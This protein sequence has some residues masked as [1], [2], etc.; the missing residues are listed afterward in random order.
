[1]TATTRSYAPGEQIADRYVHVAGFAA[2]LVGS[3][4]LFVAAVQRE[5][6]LVIFSVGVYGVGLLGMIGASAL[7]NVAASSR[8][9]EWFQRL[10]HAAIFLLIA[11][12]YT[13]FVLV[14]MAGPW[15]TGM[16][17]FVWS[18]AIGGIALKLMH[19]RSLERFSTA[20]YL[21]LGWVILVA[22]DRLLAAVSP[23]AVIM[24]ALGGVLYSLGVVFHLWKRL[25]YH[26]A[27]WHVFV[28]AAASCH[29]VAVLDG[30]VLADA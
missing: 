11:G 4:V 25:P 9:R 19:P 26:N 24:L 23:K 5:S 28:L 30:V 20:L 6:A 14:R 27:I 29:Y 16:A 13:P 17:A 8:H 3:A 10:D 7:Y 21:G 2:A 22:L 18:V 12:T 15:G 1:M